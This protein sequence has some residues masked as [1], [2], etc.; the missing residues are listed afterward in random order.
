MTK[1]EYQERLNAI[2]KKYRQENSILKREYALS[3]SKV[4]IG[5]IVQDHIGSIQVESIAITK[6]SFDPYPECVY[7]GPCITK[8][9]KLFKNNEKRYAYQSNLKS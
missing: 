1:D 9:G 7:H 5:D 8:Q 4:K 3:N 2:E 6:S